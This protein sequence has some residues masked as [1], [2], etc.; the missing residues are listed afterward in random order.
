VVD[1]ERQQVIVEESNR[2]G[3][4]KSQFLPLVKKL[5]DEVLHLLDIKV[6]LFRAELK[7]DTVAFFK[8]AASSVLLLFVAAVGFVLFSI[9]L[10][11][12]LNSYLQ[13][14][15]LCFLI[16]GLVYLIGGA[17][18]A[19]S[20]GKQFFRKK[21][22]LPQTRKELQKDKEWMKSQTSQSN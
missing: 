4:E 8:K 13:N 21:E 15:A 7:E 20:L 17:T 18:A 3:E 10:V 19:I 12:A 14:L 2:A 22:I 1:T 16:I 9:S 5:T 6:A 11:F